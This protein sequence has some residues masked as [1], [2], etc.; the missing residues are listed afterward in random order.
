MTLLEFYSNLRRE[1]AS[2][3]SGVQDAGVSLFWDNTRPNHLTRSNLK[4]IYNQYLRDAQDF[5][6]YVVTRHSDCPNPNHHDYVVDDYVVD[7][8]YGL[9]V[10]YLDEDYNWPGGQ[11]DQGMRKCVC[12]CT[13]GNEP[14]E[15][16]VIDD[17]IYRKD[18]DQ[19]VCQA[20]ER[21]MS[22][23]HTAIQ[24]AG[25]NRPR[26]SIREYLLR[27]IIK[28]NDQILPLPMDE[29]INCQIALSL[30]KAID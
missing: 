28:I 11:M 8:R 21:V 27:A 10:S 24:N 3:I 22:D 16:W 7:N 15:H 6:F 12:P 30:G 29:Y 23:I 14:T 2:E 5:G 1:L 9:Q 19:S 20:L 26:S 4:E 25:D 13:E 18:A 17:I